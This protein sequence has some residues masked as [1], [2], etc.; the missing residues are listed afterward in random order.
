MRF[1]SFKIIS[2]FRFQFWNSLKL[3]IQIRRQSS[4]LNRRS[5][6]FTFTI[7]AKIPISSTSVSFS[8][9]G[10]FTSFMSDGKQFEKYSNL[11]FNLDSAPKCVVLFPI[12][13]CNRSDKK[14]KF[15][16][17]RA[18]D[19]CRQS[20]LDPSMVR[21]FCSPTEP[22]ISETLEFYGQK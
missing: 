14:V 20:S 4:N 18:E 22:S 21:L 12:R 3:K 17:S 6:I 2:R 9:D 19:R 7:L 13:I 11:I 15:W 1:G 16:N 5:K 8:E 10:F